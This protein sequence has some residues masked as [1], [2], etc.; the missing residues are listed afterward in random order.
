MYPDDPLN[1]KIKDLL[2]T[3]DEFLDLLVAV[4]N[5]SLGEAYHIMDTLRLMD[6]LKDVRKEDMFIRYVH[7]LVT[8]Q[9]K[10][11]NYVEAGLSLQ[12]HA[13]LYGWDPNL[14]VPAVSDPKISEQSMFDRKESLCMQMIG[15]FEEGRSWENALDVYKELALQYEH[16]VFDYAKLSKAYRAIARLYENIMRGDQQVPRYYKIAYFGM[17]FPIGL[18]DKHFIVQGNAYDDLATFTDNVRQ[19]HPAAKVVM[20]GE[21][22][23]VEGQYLQVVEV[24]PELDMMHPV[25]Q[26]QKASAHVREFL[27]SSR[28][29]HFSICKDYEKDDTMVEWTE[30]V[31]YETIDHFPTILRRSEVIHVTPVRCSPINTMLDIITRRTQDS[32]TFEKQMQQREHSTDHDVL[33]KEFAKHLQSAITGP[34]QK[35]RRLIEIENYRVDGEE[36]ERPEL[37]NALKTAVLDH[38]GTLKRCFATYA[39]MLQ[40]TGNSDH[41][42]SGMC[43]IHSFLM[44]QFDQKM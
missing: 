22:D 10:H 40:G 8:I 17:G 4:H 39:S 38:V 3:I 7:Q 43:Y 12:L 28:P 19:D 6:F 37:V 36:C 44:K 15:H 13:D 9:L 27:Q 25:N 5:T 42:S 21:V 35:Y 11:H 26:R 31:V 18:R 34:V 41:L 33:T 29:K 16:V 24:L 14:I 23:N 1:E 30:K 32:R 20:A 2:S